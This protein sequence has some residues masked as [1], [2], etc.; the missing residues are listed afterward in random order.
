MT[1]NKKIL[2]LVL[3]SRNYLS[4][5]SSSSQRDI[6]GKY[7]KKIKFFHFVGEV[8]KKMEK[9]TILTKIMKAIYCSM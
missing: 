5:I 2:V 3:C 9:L 1:N 4:K 8:D 7:E 6:W